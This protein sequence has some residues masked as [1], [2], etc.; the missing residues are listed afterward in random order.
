[1]Q[2]TDIYSYVHTFIYFILQK[3]SQSPS[4]FGGVPSMA[5]DMPRSGPNVCPWYL[6]TVIILETSAS[7]WTSITYDWIWREA[8]GVIISSMERN[9]WQ[10][11]SNYQI[12]TYIGECSITKIRIDIRLNRHADRLHI[13]TPVRSDLHLTWMNFDIIGVCNGLVL[14]QC[15]ILVYNR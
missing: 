7:N 14:V 13:N 11:I 6:R 5:S 3:V 8:L 10:F 12:W 9:S 2:T 1:M 15:Q 4:P